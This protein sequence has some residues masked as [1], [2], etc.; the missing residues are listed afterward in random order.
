MVDV[1]YKPHKY[2]KKH[3]SFSSLEGSNNCGCKR[4]NQIHVAFSSHPLGTQLLGRRRYLS[5]A[6]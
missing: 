6:T 3:M 2:L 1:G 5:Q 4:T